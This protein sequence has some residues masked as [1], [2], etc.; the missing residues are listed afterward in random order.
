MPRGVYDRSKSKAQRAA[1]KAAAPVAAAAPKRKY[2]KKASAEKAELKNPNLLAEKLT[3]EGGAVGGYLGESRRNTLSAALRL[4]T[5]SRAMLQPANSSQTYKIDNLLGRV[6]DEY[7]KQLFPVEQQV[8]ET[9][10][11]ETAPA[12]SNGAP[13]PAPVAAAPVPFNPPT[14]TPAPAQS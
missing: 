13:V 9:K 14:F 1:E 12:A 7:E 2:T 3:G 11:V 5:E 10:P 8:I 6:I 4:L